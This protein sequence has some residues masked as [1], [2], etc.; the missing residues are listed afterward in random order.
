MTT[1][2][3]QKVLSVIGGQYIERWPEQESRIIFLADV[4]TYN[5]RLT[6]LTFLYGNL[7]NADLVYTAMQPQIGIDP[8]DL[9]HAQRFLAD[10]ASGRYDLKY[11]YCWIP[12]ESIHQSCRQT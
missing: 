5:Q 12:C 10:L 1:E 7:R 8:R 9:D 6:A 11:H 4:F 2:A 3:W